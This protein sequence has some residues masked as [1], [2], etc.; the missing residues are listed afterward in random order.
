MSEHHADH[1]QADESRYSPTNAAIAGVTVLVLMVAVAVIAVASFDADRDED[2]VVSGGAPTTA[3]TTMVPAEPEP[4][5][6]PT[7]PVG[8]DSALVGLTEAEVRERYPLVRVV[9]VDGEPQMATMD[10][11]PGRINLAL[12]GGVV[13]GATV[14]GC[15]EAG[16]QDPT[17]LQQACAPDPDAD[18]PDAT[19][20]LLAGSADGEFTLEV[21]TAGD[22]YHQGMS[23]V[24]DPDRTRVVDTTGVP[25][26]GADLR[27]DD[28]VWIWTGECA[29]SSPVQCEIQ[30]IVVD[31]PEG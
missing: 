25:L 3:P 14:E 1:E 6:G 2:Q 5:P 20:K 13:V 19:G 11:Q 17:W 29:E 7:E 18:G 4:V 9:E 12:E 26:T 24:V 31:R 8:A 21:G 10:L 30:A 15:E 16:P 23:V 28:V 22:Q 27:P